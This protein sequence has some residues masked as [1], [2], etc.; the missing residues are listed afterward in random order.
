MGIHINLAT[1]MHEWVRRHRLAGPVLTLGVQQVT[2]THQEFAPHLPSEFPWPSIQRPMTAVELFTA[3]GL[4]EPTTLDVSDHEGADVLF[5]LNQQE[6]PDSLR[7][8]FGVVF[9][10]GTLEHVFHIPNALA[11][12]SAFLRPGGVVIHVLPLNNWAD[13]G[14]F[15]FSPTLMFDY[16]LAARFELLESVIVSFEPRRAG[17]ASWDVFAAPRGALGQ[18]SPGALDDRAYL[19]LFLARR[20]ERSIERP[21]PVQGIYAGAIAR[22][23]RTRWFSPFQ[24]HYGTRQDRPNRMVVPM[25]R[26]VREAGFAWRAETPELEPWCDTLELPTRSRVVVLEEDLALGPAHAQHEVV[27]SIGRGAFSHWNGGILLSTSDNSDPTTNG[28]RYVAV[29]PALGS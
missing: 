2:F 10:G 4:G 3:L 24:L 14:F 27:R 12:I 6:A 22:E 16:Y 29:L 26:F 11:N 15:Q 5:D 20:T 9:N 8:R 28:R 19:H 13:H 17:G 25:R 7:G 18:G 23:A 1:L 21:I